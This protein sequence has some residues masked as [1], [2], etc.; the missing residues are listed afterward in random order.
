MCTRTSLRQD[1]VMDP[2]SL[3]EV[4]VYLNCHLCPDNPTDKD[5]GW[6][7]SHVMTLVLGQRVGILCGWWAER[8]TA[9]GILSEEG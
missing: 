4:R 2:G 7:R 9:P 3:W 1:P 6:G 5:G 8:G